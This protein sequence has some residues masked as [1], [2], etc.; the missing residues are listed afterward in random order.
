MPSVDLLGG[1][2]TILDKVKGDGYSSQF[3]MDLKIS[4]LI[5]SAHDSHL[6]FQL[7]S[8]SIFNYVIDLP[9]V[10]VSSDGLSLPEIYTLSKYKLTTID[11]RYAQLTIPHR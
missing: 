11:P 5:K 4:N 8:Q 3:E 7:C 1:I 2:D 10:S 9:L 6:V